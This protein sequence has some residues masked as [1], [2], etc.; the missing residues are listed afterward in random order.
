M[1]FAFLAASDKRFCSPLANFY[2]LSMLFG[3]SLS[4]LVSGGENNGRIALYFDC[5]SVLV[6]G[7]Y[8]SGHEERDSVIKVAT[9]LIFM[10]Y[11]VFYWWFSFCY[12]GRNATV[13]YLSIFS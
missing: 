2:F 10:A 9:A 4:Q 13:P 11:L 1:L 8:L 3:V 5:F 12:M 6:F 7:A